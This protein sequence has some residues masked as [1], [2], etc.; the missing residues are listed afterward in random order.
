MSKREPWDN[1]PRWEADSRMTEPPDIHGD[2]F[3]I[4]V[5]GHIVSLWV[6]DDGMWFREALFDKAWIPE[7][8]QL[9][10]RVKR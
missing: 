6:E 4:T 3:G 10:K 5:D 1:I 2:C 9:L 8:I 7:I